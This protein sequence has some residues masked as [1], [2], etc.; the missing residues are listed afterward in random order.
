MK[1]F[2]YIFTSL[3]FISSNAFSQNLKTESKIIS[4]NKIKEKKT[5]CFLA[6]KDQKD[7]AGY[8]VFFVKYND[9]GYPTQQIRFK[10]DGSI[11][12]KFISEYQSDSLE[13][14]RT[15]YGS[16]G[17]IY[18]ELSYTY[19]SK[20]KMIYRKE[21]DKVKGT[22]RENFYEVDSVHRISKSY[23]SFEGNKMLTGIHEY[24]QDWKKI[25]DTYYNNGKVFSTFLSEYDPSNNSIRIFTLRPGEKKLHTE[26]KYSA[27]NLLTEEINYYNSTVKLW[28]FN[29]M[30]RNYKKGDKKT[31]K[32]VYDEREL[33]S[34]QTE[35]VND[36]LVVKIKYEYLI[37]P[38]I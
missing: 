11:S 29:G 13:I 26:K 27:G 25:R 6:D 12:D 34:E 33:I 1:K 8:V 38:G 14:K 21:T 28:D 16:D 2:F 23:S 19:D 7:P 18:N 10:E 15:S 30:V 35:F 24:D 20:G 5:I 17:H 31:V 9:A 37:S 36:K 22:V 32:Y 4:R 3:V